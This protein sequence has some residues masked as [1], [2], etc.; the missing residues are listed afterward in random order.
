MLYDLQ[1]QKQTELSSLRSDFPSWS[2]N[3]EFLF[4]MTPGDDASWWRVRM[5]DRKV[6]RVLRLKD[7]KVSDG[8]FAPT[9]NN[10]LI[11]SQETGTAEIYALDWEAP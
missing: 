6:E 7:M 3:G 4:F 1:T 9:P 8:W 5:R 2:G 11:T 10:T